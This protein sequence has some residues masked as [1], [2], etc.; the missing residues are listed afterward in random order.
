MTTPR[1]LS[2]ADFQAVHNYSTPAVMAIDANGIINYANNTAVIYTGLKREE[3]I[4]NSLFDFYHDTTESGQNKAKL[5]AL[6]EIN[7]QEFI[8]ALP[9]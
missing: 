1:S 7:D 3:V 4:G 9:R 5:L 8:S 6:E 2:H